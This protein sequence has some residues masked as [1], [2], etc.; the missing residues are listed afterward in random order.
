MKYEGKYYGLP[1]V[2]KPKVMAVNTS[3]FRKNN[4][5]TPSLTEPMSVE[6]FEQAAKKL[7]SGSG[8]SKIYGSAP[9]WFNGWLKAEGGDFFAAGGKCTIDS[10]AAVAAANLMIRA[11]SAD[12]FAPTLLDAQGQ[13]MFYW[14]SVS[15]LA[16][17]PDFGPWDIAKL[18]GLKSPN[19]QLVP[20]PGNGSLLEVNGLSVL[21]AAKPEK[22]AAAEKFLTFMSTNTAA[23]SLLTTTK[24]SL[25]VPVTT[26]GV[27]SF[28]A[29]AP[30][31]NL[32]AF[33]IAAGQSALGV[34]VKR[35]SDIT[36]N[37][38]TALSSRTAIGSGH[39]NPAV[40]LRNL[41][42]KCPSGLATSS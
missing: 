36:G 7:T 3:L 10:P 6:S 28:E 42:S 41:Q 22:A 19:Y 4:V 15:R 29:T 25:G 1:F 20:V 32:H 37:I 39:E 17:Q 13:D 2:L 16:I 26:A 38:G 31:L 27:K 40:V 23:Q 30:N 33:V 35:Y 8:K 18:V 5:P 12:G 21:K 11:Q 9:L 34:S 24:S 14:L